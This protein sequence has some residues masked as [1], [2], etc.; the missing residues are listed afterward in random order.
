VYACVCV[1]G[2]VAYSHNVTVVKDG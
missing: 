1:H 2:N